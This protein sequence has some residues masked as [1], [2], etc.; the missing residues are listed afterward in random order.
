MS[1]YVTPSQP[2]NFASPVLE[3]QFERDWQTPGPRQDAEL[4]QNCVGRQSAFE[5][6]GAESPLWDGSVDASAND[7][8]VG[9]AQL[10]AAVEASMHF[11]VNKQQISLP[12]HVIP[13]Q[14]AGVGGGSGQSATA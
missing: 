9:F 5:P 11:P 8:G 1:E 7:A 4:A 13:P 6:H 12:A 3:P 10:V 2:Q 14:I